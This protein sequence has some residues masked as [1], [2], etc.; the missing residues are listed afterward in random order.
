MISLDEL[1]IL[2]EDLFQLN[3][4]DIFVALCTVLESDIV[5]FDRLVDYI[6]TVRIFLQVLDIFDR[7]IFLRL[8]IFRDDPLGKGCNNFAHLK[9]DQSQKVPGRNIH[10]IKFQ[11]SAQLIDGS[12]EVSD[13]GLLKTLIIIET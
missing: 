11:T 10:F 4:S 9:I 7:N 1:R 6:Q 13:L 8:N 3:H 2:S 12:A 5:L